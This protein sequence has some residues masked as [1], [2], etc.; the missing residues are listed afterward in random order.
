V[1]NHYLFQSSGFLGDLND[2]G[3]I[4]I[5]D[6]LITV[7]VILN[8]EFNQLAD[9]NVDGIIDVIDILLIVN[10]ILGN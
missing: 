2:D 8:N 1:K 3:L 7:E 5:S 6:V 10:I 9:L 4:N